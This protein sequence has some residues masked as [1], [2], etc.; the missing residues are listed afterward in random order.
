VQYENCSTDKEMQMGTQDETD[1]LEMSAAA[2]TV[3]CRHDGGKAL[4]RDPDH[5][6]ATGAAGPTGFAS[7]LC[8][9]LAN[10]ARF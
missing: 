5:H 1:A 3:D 9:M 8:K 4:R 10:L 2:R 7:E 6:R